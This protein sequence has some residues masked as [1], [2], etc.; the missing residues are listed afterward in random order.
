MTSGRA[1]PFFG[2]R[3]VGIGF[4]TQALAVG[5]TFHAF[6]VFL[7]PVASEL[8][9]S[10]LLT[11][12]GP[13]AVAVVAALVA[14]LL[15][16]IVDRGAA[17]SLITAGSLLLA[18]GFAM[19]AGVRSVVTFG[20]VFAVVIGLASSMCGTLPASKLVTSW[21]VKHRGRALGITAMGTSLGGFLL[22]PLAA[23]GIGTIGWRST[24]LCFAGMVGLGLTPVAW[25]LVVDRPETVGQHPD[26]VASSR[27]EALRESRQG[28]AAEG[29]EWTTARLLRSRNFWIITLAVGLVFGATG[30]FVIHLVPFA[31]DGGISPGRAAW[32]QSTYAAGGMVGKYLFGRIADRVAL[33]TAFLAAIGLQMLAWSGLMLAPDEALL[34]VLGI[35]MGLS[36]GGRLPVWNAMVAAAFGAGSFGRAMGLM[37]P[38]MLPLS[39]AGAPLG[40]WIHDRTGSYDL[41]FQGGLVVLVVAA[42]LACSLRLP[43]RSS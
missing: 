40:G 19:L 20:L 25:R 37:S 30:F 18:V 12:V 36:A 31:T 1:E 13:T 10:R 8:G 23:W 2:W 4:A 32:I 7:K 16:R 39:F 9:A 27:G 34:F 24:C 14:P 22:P 33:R 43:A 5:A 38:I 17:R 3:M 11:V 42:L 21:F 26:G 41:A 6:G 28:P 15:G 29:E 35:T